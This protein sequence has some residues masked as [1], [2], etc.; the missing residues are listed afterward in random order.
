MS[1]MNVEAIV[2]FLEGRIK[3]SNLAI[4]DSTPPEAARDIHAFLCSRAGR[5][6][7]VESLRLGK[8]SMS[9]GDISKCVT[10]YSRVKWLDI[11]VCD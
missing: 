9:L 5:K 1:K 3:A 2:A 8:G 4:D 6:L 7:A 11:S 10:Q